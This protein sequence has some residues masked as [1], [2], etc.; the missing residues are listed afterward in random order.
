MS[1][2]TAG[3]DSSGGTGASDTSSPGGAK[4]WTLALV[5][6]AMFML[7]LDVSVVNV[8]LPDLRISLGASFSDLQWV[9]DAYTL[10][11]AAFLVTGGSLADRLG[12]KKVF[13]LGF[14]I[15][16]LSSLMAG[17]AQDVLVLNISRGVQGIGA[18]IMFS[19]GPALIGQEFRGAA[20]GKAFGIFGAVA[21]LALACGP[22]VGGFL[23]D[24]LSWRWIFL[25]NVPIGVI[26]LAVGVLKLRES[27]DPKPY[28]IDWAGMV[29]F[30]LALGMLVLGFVRGE[31]EGWTSPLILGLFA[32]ALV[33]LG[34]FVVI[35]SKRGP[36][37]MFDL[38]LLRIP[39]FAGLCAATFLSNAATLAMVFLEVSYLQNVLGHTPWE[40]GLRFLPM[41]V[42]MFLVAALTGNL[43][44]KIAPGILLGS[45]LVLCAIGMGLILLVT[46]E[47]SW[48]ALLP[49]LIVTGIGFGLFNPP[50]AAVTIGVVAPERGGMASGMGETFQQVGVAVGIA[51]FGALFHQKVVDG[52][53]AS[54]AAAGL[55]EGAYAAGQA[56]ATGGTAGLDAVVSSPAPGVVDAARG[57]F[58]DG[59]TDVIFM[60]AVACGIG[61]L[62]AFFLIRRRDLH[63]SAQVHSEDNAVGTAAAM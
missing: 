53:I 41:M 34:V 43:V 40:A 23:T 3:H 11:L 35:E 58:V 48:T 46:P 13:I 32:G 50:R 60:G 26:A 10:T 62:L 19:V 61:A 55:G 6:L 8:A 22:M 54:E 29:V 30:G 56:V 42:T 44:N 36:E 39:T 57:A 49:S 15:F 25:V 7:M 16:I 20:R 2:E 17:L 28:G 38:S 59:L 52:F 37:A 14:L 33:L 45:S 12:R 63:E 31:A 5:C 47:S 18:A 24:S 4:S 9:I 21:G 1:V 27:K 51:A